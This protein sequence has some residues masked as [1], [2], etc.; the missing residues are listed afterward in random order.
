MKAPKKPAAEPATTGHEWD[1]IEEYNNPLPRWWLYIFY[2]CIAFS[3]VYV[4]LY[5]A[6]PGIKGYTPGILGYSAR[7]E[8]EKDLEAVRAQRLL[9]VKGIEDIPVADI[10]KN[11][12][13]MRAAVEGGRS[14]F[15]LHCSQCHGAGAAGGKGYPNLND[16]DWLWGGDMEAI[17]TTLLH[18]IRYPGD[19]QTRQSQMPAFGKDGILKPAEIDQLV[20]YVRKISGQEAK[21]PMAAAGAPLFAANCAVC[22]GEAGEGN[23]SVGAPN[24]ANGIWLYGGDRASLQATIYGARAGVMP[25]WKDRLSETTIRELTAYVHSLGGGQ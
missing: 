23:Q 12:E 8:V 1:G 18:G 24:L 19:E 16:D 9:A 20:E 6:L 15:K 11:P 5:P 7:L 21:A 3:F 14:A 13:L 4:I 10:P 22:H 2:A 25:G 17:H